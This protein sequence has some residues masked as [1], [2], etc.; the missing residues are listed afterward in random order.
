MQ[1]H[2]MTNIRL[3]CARRSDNAVIDIISP[4]LHAYIDNQSGK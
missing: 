3:T 4:T 1:Y 2:V